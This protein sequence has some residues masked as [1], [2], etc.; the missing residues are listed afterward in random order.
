[1]EHGAPMSGV[2]KDR[3]L[4]VLQL[5]ASGMTAVLI[6]QNAANP[7]FSLLRTGVIFSQTAQFARQVCDTT[8][9]VARNPEDNLTVGPPGASATISFIVSAV[10]KSSA[11]DRHFMCA[12]GVLFQSYNAHCWLPK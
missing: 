10:L 8:R 7:T 12:S 11:L 9:A 4:R 6:P 5:T 2:R 1:M 3:L